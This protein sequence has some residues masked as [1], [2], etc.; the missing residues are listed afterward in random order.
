[1][2][3]RLAVASS[4]GDSCH[5]LAGTLSLVDKDRFEKQRDAGAPLNLLYAVSG[6]LFGQVDR[7][8]VGG[9]V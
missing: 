3:R 9:R 6:K 2:C 8:F 1:M 7:V 4:T 5:R